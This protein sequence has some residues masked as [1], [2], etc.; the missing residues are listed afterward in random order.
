MSNKRILADIAEL[1][2][3]IYAESGI[4]YS[5][6]DSNIREGYACIFGP[7]GTPYEDC[8][9]LYSFSIGDGFPFDPPKVLFHTNDGI[10]RFHPNMYKEGKVCLSI[11]HTW[12]GPKWASTMRLSTILLT[13]Q[14]LMDT[15]PIL[16]EPGYHNLSKNLRDGYKN[17]VENSCIQYILDRAER[18]EPD[19]FKP[20]SSIF[21]ERL[22]GILER[23]EKRLR[24]YLDEDEGELI[25]TNIPYQM[26]GSTNYVKALE[27]VIKLKG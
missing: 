13:L 8:P 26:H 12:E 1:E 22:P 11:L 19:A 10:T 17:Y 15:D 16:H 24:K 18:P 21:K 20:F 5:V 6:N 14:S 27:R 4:Y 23:L 7:E 9:M 3:P 25:F 2:K